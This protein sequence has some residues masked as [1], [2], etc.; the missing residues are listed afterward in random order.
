MEPVTE[1]SLLELKQVHELV[2]EREFDLSTGPQQFAPGITL[3]YCMPG[4]VLI[5]YNG[6]QG[7]VFAT[8]SYW[9]L[10]CHGW[11]SRRP[12][13]MTIVIRRNVKLLKPAEFELWRRYTIFSMQGHF[14][15]MKP[16]TTIG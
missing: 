7:H 10:L 1:M 9:G 6:A 14:D 5:S 2:E 16:A 8:Y 12:E 15:R 4:S 11:E 3:E 13:P